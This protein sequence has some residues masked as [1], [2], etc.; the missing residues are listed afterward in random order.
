[1]TKNILQNKI[2]KK[3]RKKAY[4]NSINTEKQ[5]L[6]KYFF[7][8]KTFGIKLLKK[9]YWVWLRKIDT[10]KGTNKRIHRELNE[11]ERQEKEKKSTLI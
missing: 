8:L 10:Q 7:L 4:A 9:W 6:F 3:S 2:N 11:R 1:M 5:S